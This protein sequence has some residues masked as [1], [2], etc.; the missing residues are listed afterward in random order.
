MT[1][2]GYCLVMLISRVCCHLRNYL[3]TGRPIC[4]VERFCRVTSCQCRRC[5][6]HCSNCCVSFEYR[7]WPIDA[8]L[9]LVMNL[10]SGGQSILSSD[11]RRLRRCRRLCVRR[12]RSVWRVL[13]GMTDATTDSALMCCNYF[14]L[15]LPVSYLLWLQLVNVLC[16][17]AFVVDP[18]PAVDFRRHRS[19]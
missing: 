7:M 16:Q 9:P 13:F 6:R 2:C 17:P 10:A 18:L 14:M 15:I 19:V 8:C 5:Q 11:W 12:H 1:M 3:D 4:L